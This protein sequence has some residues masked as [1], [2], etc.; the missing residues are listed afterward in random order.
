MPF[1]RHH[2][3]HSSCVSGRSSQTRSFRLCIFSFFA[4]VFAFSVSS[5]FSFSSSFTFS[6]TFTYSSNFLKSSSAAA[7]RKRRAEVSTASP[8]PPPVR[9]GHGSGGRPMRSAAG[10]Q[11]Q[12][13]QR[14]RGSH[15]PVRDCSTLRPRLRQDARPHS[16]GGVFCARRPAYFTFSTSSLMA[17]TGVCLRGAAR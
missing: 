16:R 3:A 10:Q 7:A 17:L 1:Q 11:Q 5:I 14:H 4:A 9:A 6:S 2:A 13:Q 8:T 15:A 12:G